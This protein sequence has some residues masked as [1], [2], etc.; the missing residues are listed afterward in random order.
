MSLDRLAL[1][2]GGSRTREVSLFNASVGFE[3]G[4]WQVRFWGRNLND[5]QWLITVFPSVAQTGSATGYPNQPRSYG[6][7]LRRTF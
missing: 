7:T 6:A 2:E 5:D 4:D 1:G 3:K